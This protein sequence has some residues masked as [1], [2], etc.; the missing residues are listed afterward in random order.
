VATGNAR[1]FL[2]VG[3]IARRLDEP[4]HRVEYAIRSRDIRPVG[5][6]GNL[7]VF[8]DE[9]L[10]TIADVLREIDARLARH[11]AAGREGEL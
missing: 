8:D 5:M 3:A 6:A 9:A 10:E 1:S 7:R 2:T 4:L 11:E